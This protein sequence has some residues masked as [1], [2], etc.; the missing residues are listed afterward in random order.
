MTGRRA[1]PD[2][3]GYL[4]AVAVSVLTMTIEVLGLLVWG[5]GKAFLAEPVEVVVTFGIVL[6][7]VS[8]AAVPSATVVV[9]VVHVL[10]GRVRTQSVHVLAFALGGAL[11]GALCAQRLPQLGALLAVAVGVAS[12]VGR[13]AVI[14]IRP[15]APPPVDDDFRPGRTAC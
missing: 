15:L 1:T 11:V 12:A 7:L 6:L 13:A 10:L 3:A 4:V 8:L 5:A 2:A 9:L 14:G